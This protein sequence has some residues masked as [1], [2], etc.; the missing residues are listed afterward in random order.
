M[1]NKLILIRHGR[2]TGNEDKKMYAE[3]DSAI[4]LTMLGVK[5]ALNAGRQLGEILNTGYFQWHWHDVHA[6][7]SGYTRAQQTARIV[8][9]TMGMRHIQTIEARGINERRYSQLIIDDQD[10]VHQDTDPH[11]RPGPGGESMIECR[12]RFETWFQHH[13]EY[14]LTD[15]DVI[16]FMHGEVLKAA[17]AYLLNLDDQEMMQVSCPNGVPFIYERNPDTGGYTP[18]PHQFPRWDP[19]V[20][21]AVR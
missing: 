18:S 2:S 5:Q 10:E 11:W 20:E 3:V 6:F 21:E 1:T 15:A 17:T 9:D 7:A 4:C 12:R 8:L 14:L 13:A 16:L 19:T